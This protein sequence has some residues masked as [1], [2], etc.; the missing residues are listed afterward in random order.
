MEI[1]DDLIFENSVAQWKNL[2]F[3]FIYFYVLIERV[4][5]FL[6]EIVTWAQEYFMIMNM[7]S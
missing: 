2:H 5:I 1:G 3:K 6:L 4:F 7:K